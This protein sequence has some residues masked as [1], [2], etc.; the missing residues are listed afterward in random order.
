MG[1]FS[2]PVDTGAHLH[3]C[4]STCTGAHLPSKYHDYRLLTLGT[5]TEDLVYSCRVVPRTPGKQYQW[6]PKLSWHLEED[7]RVRTRCV[8]I[9]AA[10]VLALV[11][12]LLVV[13]SQQASRVPPER[14]PLGG[15]R[16]HSNLIRPEPPPHHSMEQ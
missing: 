15:M 4:P 7:R 10:T 12:R 14:H 6:M 2:V 13:T 9:R 8:C 5:S 3:R 16:A 11:P 1:T